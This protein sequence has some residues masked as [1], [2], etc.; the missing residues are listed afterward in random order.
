[1]TM[2]ETDRG[3]VTPDNVGTELNTQ[4]ASSV[5]ANQNAPARETICAVIVT[6]NPD[7][8]LLS[9]TQKVI[10]QVAHIAVVDNGSTESGVGRLQQLVDNQD[11]HIIL[12]YRNEGVARALNQGAE[13]AAQQGY[14]WIL[15]L[16]QDTVVA[17][18]LVDS[19]TAAYHAFPKQSSLAVIGSN[20]TSSVN[21]KPA[22]ANQDGNSSWGAEVTAVITSGSLVSLQAFHEIGGFREEFFVDCVDLEYCLRARSQGFHIAMTSKPLMQHSIGNLIEHRLP[23]KT[24]G[25]SNHSPW[26]QYFMTR[27][28]LILAGEYL[29]SEPRWVLT[30]LCSRLKSLLLICLFEKKRFNK[31]AYCLLG[32]LDGIRGKTDRFA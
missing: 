30:T 8:D 17:S 14:R 5:Q 31:L 6:R 13:W 23:W 28:T 29:G 32:A 1:M 9:R 4:R 7:G 27:N 12:N 24:T 10:P 20:Y 26:R 15:S 11:V 25:A 18:D 19:L 3:T 16:D 21:G 22:A 2:L